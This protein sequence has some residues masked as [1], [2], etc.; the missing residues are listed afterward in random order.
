MDIQGGIGF[1][2]SNFRD[3]IWYEEFVLVKKNKK[4]TTPLS[5]PVVTE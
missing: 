4:N 1:R 5:L 3:I 2:H